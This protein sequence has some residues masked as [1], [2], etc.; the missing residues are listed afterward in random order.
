[1]FSFCA[2]IPSLHLAFSRS[3]GCPASWV[4]HGDSCYYIDD[5]RH[6][7]WSAARQECQKIGADLAIITSAQQ[8]SFIFDLVKKQN[9]LTAWGVWIGLQR[10]ADSKFY[11]VDGTPLE[12]H[13]K[14]WNV[15]EPNNYR[16]ARE[17][18]GHMYGKQTGTGQ[19][20]TWNDLPCGNRGP[21]GLLCQK[22]IKGG[23]LILNRNVVN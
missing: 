2:M 3:A 6:L 10:K 7:G 17:D 13:Y 14:N 11:W 23:Q 12:G 20:G 1:M 22:T 19:A 21:S 16:G 15:G 4:A 18:C 5:S 9:K 8:Q